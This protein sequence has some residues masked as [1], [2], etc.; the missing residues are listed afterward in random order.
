VAAAAKLALARGEDSQLAF[1]GAAL[2]ADFEN[3]IIK[4]LTVK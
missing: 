4:A 3:A 2:Q 1:V